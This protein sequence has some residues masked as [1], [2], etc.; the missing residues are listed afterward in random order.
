MLH[1][2]VYTKSDTG[3]EAV[4]L[5]QAYSAGEPSKC[6]QGDAD[7]REQEAVGLLFHEAHG[8]T[9]SSADVVGDR[10]VGL[11]F[12]HRELVALPGSKV[13]R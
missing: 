10:S 8:A 12:V 13:A 4:F 11:R 3:R 7:H 6:E 1:K 9:A 2:K 5:P